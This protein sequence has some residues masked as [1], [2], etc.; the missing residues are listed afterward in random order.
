MRQGFDQIQVEP[1]RHLDHGVS[2]DDTFLEGSNRDYR[3]DR[4]T[5]NI[6]G[7]E[8]QLLIH[9]AQNTARVRVDGN[10]R[11]VIVSEPSY[12][13]LTHDRIVKSRVITQRGINEGRNAA[14]SRSVRGGFC[15][16]R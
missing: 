1:G 2:R 16:D 9:D 8:R 14:H 6:S 12:R 4:G 11:A 7:G 13:C 3:L 10:N 5:R 15:H